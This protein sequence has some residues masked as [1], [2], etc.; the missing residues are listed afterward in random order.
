MNRAG[1]DLGDQTL[2]LLAGVFR[3]VGYVGS[4][5]CPSTSCE[6]DLWPVMTRERRYND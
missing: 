2:A 4:G 3:K 1:A 6:P 5:V